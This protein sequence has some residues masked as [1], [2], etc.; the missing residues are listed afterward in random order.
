VQLL[1]VTTR[2]ISYSLQTLV[3]LT[4]MIGGAWL[5]FYSRETQCVYYA[6][7][8][9]I[10]FSGQP[11]VEPF[12]LNGILSF[13]DE[14]SNIKFLNLRTGDM[15][16][17]RL[18][19]K[20]D[21]ASL[22]NNGLSCCVYNTDGTCD[23]FDSV[24]GKQIEQVKLSACATVI[25]SGTIAGLLKDGQDIV[26]YDLNR[27]AL[28][29]QI[30]CNKHAIFLKLSRDAE[31]LVWI[32]SELN[33]H[34]NLVRSGEEII[35]DKVDVSSSY[36]ASI[37]FS[38][39]GRFLN[40]YRK[41]KLFIW[42]VHS[43]Q[44]KTSIVALKGEPLKLLTAA[45]KI[46]LVTQDNASLFNLE[47][48]NELLEIKD[49]RNP[50]SIALSQFGSFVAAM[51][52]NGHVSIFKTQTGNRQV[53]DKCDFQSEM[54]NFV[55]PQLLLIGGGRSQFSVIVNCESGT[56][57]RKLDHDTGGQS[58]IAYSDAGN[59]VAIGNRNITAWRIIDQNLVILYRCIGG[60]AIVS[61]LCV[62]LLIKMQQVRRSPP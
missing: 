28:L 36:E 6:K 16:E 34:L 10:G 31:S 43:G 49:V 46:L 21:R 53:A 2:K 50:K 11:I 17:A 41:G 14:F 26:C 25:N 38:D 24:T 5:I 7:G 39:D 54:L 33:F 23:L 4:I 32:D 57:T 55:S 62:L 35:G 19:G 3:L 13:V 52:R 8:T 42:D 59:F 48:G 37:C 12:L 27:N 30:P 29:S 60:I 44:L 22:F 45:D 18:N 20:F 61:C 58:T 56:V 40:V 9:V 47:N 51:G 1:G 15:N